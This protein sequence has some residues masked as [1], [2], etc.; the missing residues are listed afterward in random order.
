MDEIQ[1]LSNDP[2]YT[3]RLYQ[4]YRWV[5]DQIA[6]LILNEAL[7][8]KYHILWE[9]TGNGISWIEREIAR[10]NALDYETV[11]VFPLVSVPVLLQRVTDRAMLEKQVG[12][13]EEEIKT[14]SRNAQNNLIAFL[15]KHD[16]PAWI[17]KNVY[18]TIKSC[19][20]TRIIIFT[21]E[22]N[23]AELLYDSDEVVNTVNRTNMKKYLSKLTQNEEFL[24]FFEEKA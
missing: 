17:L 11:I 4:Y 20:P 19:N 22:T 24:K 18:A 8:Q 7:T 23:Q 13:S 6:D 15:K 1:A 2:L 21:N 16:C 5:A 14:Q 12:A 10:I 3:Q 9:T